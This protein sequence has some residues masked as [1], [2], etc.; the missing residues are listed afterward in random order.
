MD[1]FFC[2]VGVRISEVPL[3]F[4]RYEDKRALHG[5]KDGLDV[6]AKILKYSSHHLK[7]GG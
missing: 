7:Q 2:P 6:A 3:Y 5:G 1:T 4:E